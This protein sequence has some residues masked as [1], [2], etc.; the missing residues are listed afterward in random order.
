MGLLPPPPP[1]AAFPNEHRRQWAGVEEAKCY[2]AIL[3]NYIRCYQHPALMLEQ[4]KANGG[5]WKHLPIQSLS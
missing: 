2:A 5:R 4:R 3:L 1:P